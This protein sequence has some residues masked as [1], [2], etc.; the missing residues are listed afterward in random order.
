MGA[1]PELRARRR[2][3]NSSAARIIISSPASPTPTPIPT[4][5]P[6]DRLAEG[7]SSV[8]PALVFVAVAENVCVEVGVAE[9]EAGEEAESGPFRIRIP[10]AFIPPPT[11]VVL[12]FW[13]PDV[14]KVTV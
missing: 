10:Y 6:V 14:K 8:V 3:Q 9:T 4:L 11:A 1:T 13:L 2:V 7:C 12:V 5:A